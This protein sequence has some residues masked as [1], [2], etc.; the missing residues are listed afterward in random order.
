MRSRIASAMAVFLF[1]SAC[2]EE[3][4]PLDVVEQNTGTAEE[5]DED[6]VEE[7]AEETGDETDEKTGDEPSCDG[8]IND[9]GECLEGTPEDTH[10]DDDSWDDR[11]DR[12]GDNDI[13]YDKGSCQWLFSRLQE[14]LEE[15]GPENQVC[16]D[17]ATHYESCSNE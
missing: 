17:L 15:L 8:D 6:P 7:T 1:L 13:P 5:T 9:A 11:F 10:P 2:D 4:I 3:Q 12:N 14:C 16:A